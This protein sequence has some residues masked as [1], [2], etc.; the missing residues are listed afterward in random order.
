MILENQYY[1]EKAKSLRNLLKKNGAKKIIG[2]FDQ[3]YKSD[4]RWNH[5]YEISSKNYEFLLEKVITN[6]WLGL[7]L[8]PKIASDIRLK[9]KNI[10]NILDQ[11]LNTGRCI[12]ID[13]GTD[14]H[15]NFEFPPPLVSSACDIS[16]HDSLI[17]ATAGMESISAGN[18]VLFY[19]DTG[20]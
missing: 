10:N 1:V 16:I 2:Y 13:E 6:K 5:G 17:S 4:K 14:S 8:K 3:G 9:L 11:A 12:I 19:D 18:N 15:K 7:I 20:F